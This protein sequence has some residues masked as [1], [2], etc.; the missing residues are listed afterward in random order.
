MEAVVSFKG[1]PR[2]LDL[3]RKALGYAVAA[4]QDLQENIKDENTHEGVV[5]I[6]ATTSNDA[7]GESLEREG[8]FMLLLSK[9]NGS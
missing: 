7:F 9:L 6:K 3:I 2:D 8:E 4:E 1:T 5:N